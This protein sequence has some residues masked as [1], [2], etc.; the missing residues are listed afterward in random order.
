MTAF[1]FTVY[2]QKFSPFQ[3]KLLVFILWLEFKVCV[4]TEN[5]LKDVVNLMDQI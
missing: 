4:F 3:I 2:G 5:F 1:Y